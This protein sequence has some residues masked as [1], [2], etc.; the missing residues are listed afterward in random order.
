MCPQYERCPVPL[1]PASPPCTELT[2]DEDTDDADDDD[3][4]DDSD[5]NNGDDV[6]L[7]IQRFTFCYY[8]TLSY[9]NIKK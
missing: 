5:D 4:E 3:N 6:P 7:D 1:V 9:K 8:F 2:R